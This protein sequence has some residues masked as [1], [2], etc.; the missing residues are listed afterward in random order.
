MEKE[1]LSPIEDQPT[2]PQ[3]AIQKVVGARLSEEAREQLRSEANKSFARQERPEWT[4]FETEKTIE[5][6]KMLAFINSD[7]NTLLQRFSR[8]EFDVPAANYHLLNEEGWKA[9]RGEELF[10][11]GSYS[12]D[13]QATFIRLA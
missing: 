10:T 1:P 3:G 6:Q 11:G 13:D 12:I 9:I 2:P 5:Q 8:G 4:R 7:T